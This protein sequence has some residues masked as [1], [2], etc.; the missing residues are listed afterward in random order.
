MVLSA[1]TGTAFQRAVID[2][3]R[4]GIRIGSELQKLVEETAENIPIKVSS[5][6]LN[7]I[8]ARMFVVLP[9][10]YLL[11][12][13]TF[14]FTWL[15]WNCCQRAV[16]GGGAGPPIPYRIYVDSGV[17]LLCLFALAPASPLIAPA[18]CLYFLLCLPLLRWTMI[19]L[20]KPK[21]DVGGGRF[22]FIF[23]VCVS[24]ML[25]GQI[26]LTTMMLLKQATGP[27]LTAIMPFLPTIFYRYTLRRKYLRA[28]KDAAL[29]QTSLLDGW[30]NEDDATDEDREEFRKFLVDCHKAAYVP[31]CIASGDAR[32]L[33]TAEPAVVI[34][35]EG[36]PTDDEAISQNLDDS[37]DSFPAQFLG[38]ARQMRTYKN[39]TVNSFT[40]PQHRARRSIEAG[41]A[42]P[43][44]PSLP[45]QPG[46][47]MRR[48]SFTPRTPRAA[49]ES[50]GS[51]ASPASVRATVP[52]S[53][54]IGSQPSVGAPISRR[55][56]SDM[57]P[58]QGRR[59][60]FAGLKAPVNSSRSPRP[61]SA[62][63]LLLSP[64][65]QSQRSQPGKMMRRTSRSARVSMSN[66]PLSS[67]PELPFN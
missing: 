11:Q 63:N 42:L 66:A 1:F 13:N 24:G 7:W 22:P 40:T 45:L 15:G 43:S 38:S 56:V 64:L 59:A 46:V 26:L 25:V 44:L 37:T 34:P 54:V 32:T 5:N 49:P 6:W 17:V 23:D 65:Q 53:P 47:M 41:T 67:T 28:F 12:T 35:M 31:V 51:Y 57:S 20:Y 2:G 29:L 50:P 55:G 48:Q 8:I 9:T 33:I 58:G 3:F 27:A 19:F 60:S 18:A 14:L 52:A 4:D 16:R 61:G 30:D 39:T 10:Q 36:D 62:K 21:F